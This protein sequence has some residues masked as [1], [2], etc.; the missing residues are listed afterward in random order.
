MIIG[1]VNVLLMGRGDSRIKY[2]VLNKNRGVIILFITFG[3]P[4][5]VQVGLEKFRL[6]KDV[7]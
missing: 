6:V 5:L 4:L 1:R 7:K 3:K 2:Y